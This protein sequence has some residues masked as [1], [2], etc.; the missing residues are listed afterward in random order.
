MCGCEGTGERLN[1]FDLVK[2]FSSERIEIGPHVPGASPN[3]K[4]HV[5]M[6]ESTL[7][8]VASAELARPSTRPP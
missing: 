6:A 7:L 8:S 4:V 5:R 1:E 2:Q 3:L